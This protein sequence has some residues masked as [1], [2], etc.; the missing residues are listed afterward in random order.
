MELSAF[1]DRV[2]DGVNRPQEDIDGP[3]VGVVGALAP[4]VEYA[5]DGSDLYIERFQ[6]DDLSLLSERIKL[7]KETLD[8][9]GAMIVANETLLRIMQEFF[10]DGEDFQIHQ[11]T[12]LRAF[13]KSCI[14]R[15]ISDTLDGQSVTDEWLEDILSRVKGF[16][17]FGYGNEPEA[18]ESIPAAQEYYHGRPIETTDL[19]QGV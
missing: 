1:I 10:E 18:A 5:D 4:E 9:A 13:V 19:L 15:E 2:P 7:N 3:R 11:N 8:T 16:P 14:S 6:P 12:D 17:P